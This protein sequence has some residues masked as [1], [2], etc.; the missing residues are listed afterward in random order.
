MPGYALIRNPSKVII[1]DCPKRNLSAKQVRQILGCDL[2]INGGLYN[3][4]TGKPVCHLRI[5]GKTLATEDWTRPGLGWD[6]GSVDVRMMEA[7][8][9]MQVDNFI[10]CVDLVWNEQARDLTDPGELGG[11][12]GRTVWGTMPDGSLMAW[13]SSDNDYANRHTVEEVQSITLSMGVKDAMMNDT[14]SSSQLSSTSQEIPSSNGRCTRNYI[15]FWGDV[16]IYNTVDNFNAAYNKQPEEN[17]GKE[18]VVMSDDKISVQLWTKSDAVKNG[19]LTPKGIMVHSTATPGV[20]A[21]TF[22]DRWDR[23]GVGASVHFFVDDK[24]II[25]CLPL[26]KK[27]GHAGGS[28][29]STHLSFEMCEPKGI[30]YNSSGSAIMSY[31]PPAGYF[32]GIWD[33]AV[34]LCAKLCKDYGFDPLNKNQ[35]LCHSEGYSKGIATNHA[36]V[37]HWFPK[38]G[39]DMND[40]RAAVKALMEKPEP[41]PETPTTTTLYKVQVGAFK[42]KSYAEAL[43]KE[44]QG[45]GYTTYL[46]EKDGYYKVQLGAFAKPANAQNLANE[47]ESKGYQTYIVVVES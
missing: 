12:R 3:L 6:T 25:Q 20:N 2:V 46:V 9:M 43:E 24:D 29:N 11:S 39:L 17:E 4:S 14:G 19:S 23:R 31:N 47:L 32:K 34:W 22:H 36:D 44:L 28:A 5:D 45:K 18:D 26:N 37:M 1:Y 40:F 27:A 15:C 16:E 38:E 33:N 10:D 8:D 35:L 30:K 42:N 13:V 7:N 21:Q 41:E